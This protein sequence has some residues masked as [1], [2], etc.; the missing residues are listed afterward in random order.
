MWKIVLSVLAGYA[1]IVVATVAFFGALGR[2][3]PARF[4]PEADQPPGTALLLL[5]L[6]W[7]LG[8]ALAGGWV[9]ATIAPRRAA[10][11]SLVAVIAVLGLLMLF[12]PSGDAPAGAQ[13]AWYRAALPVVGV[14]GA[15]LGGWLKLA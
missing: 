5:V 1:V 14:T 2:L 8:A 13:P 4:G 15:W 7:G 6:A 12:F 10:V 3:A 9:T 11:L